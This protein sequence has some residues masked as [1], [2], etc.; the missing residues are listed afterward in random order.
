M[1]VLLGGLNRHTR[2]GCLTLWLNRGN[3]MDK[4]KKSSIP[5]TDQTLKLDNHI[6]KIRVRRKAD[7]LSIL[8]IELLISQYPVVPEQAA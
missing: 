2:N 7:P 5:A 1:V 6:I 4:N 8:E 3:C